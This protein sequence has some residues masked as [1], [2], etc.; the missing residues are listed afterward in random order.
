M[1]SDTS[2]NCKP[3]LLVATAAIFKL[4]S[5]ATSVASPAR[6]S[7]PKIIGL[8]NWEALTTAKP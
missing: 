8:L 3:P 6:S 1:G 7:C 5:T 2:T 4:A